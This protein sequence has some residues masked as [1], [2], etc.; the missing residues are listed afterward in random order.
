VR[1]TRYVLFEDGL[2]LSSVRNITR[3][4]THL[5][6]RALTGRGENACQPR[7][8]T[9]RDRLNSVFY[10]T[11]FRLRRAARNEMLSP[12]QSGLLAFSLDAKLAAVFKADLERG[13]VDFLLEHFD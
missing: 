8:E 1:F 11:D 4:L 2:R 6:K 12:R 5:G 13:H 10:G 9:M 3:V 7:H